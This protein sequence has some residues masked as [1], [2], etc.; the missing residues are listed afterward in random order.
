VLLPKAAIRCLPVTDSHPCP[1][2]RAL[3]GTDHCSVAALVAARCQA[4]PDAPF[5]LWGDTLLTYGQAFARM[6]GVANRLAAA[7]L[8]GPDSRVAILMPKGPD[9]ILV[10]IGAQM[11]GCVTTIIRPDLTGALLDDLL[12][13]LKP[14]CIVT[15]GAAIVDRSNVLTTVDGMLPAVLP[16]GHATLSLSPGT[17][18]GLRAV[19]PTAEAALMFTSGTTGRSKL[20]RVG[21]AYFCRGAAFLAQALAI[22]PTDVLL[23]WAPQS[24]VGNQVDEVLCCIVGGAAL[25]MVPGFSRSGFLDQLQQHKVTLFGGFSNVFK[26]LLTLP[27]GPADHTHSLRL[28]VAINTPRPLRDTF[29][30][31]F[32]VPLVDY[33][34]MTECSIATLP[35]VNQPPGS[36][37]RASP[38]VQIAILDAAGWHLPHGHTGRIALRPQV[39]DA[40]MRGYADD[41]AATVL[42]T[43]G[44]WFQT[45]DLGQ[46]DDDGNLFFADRLNDSIRSGGEN[47]A[48]SE[49]ESAIMSLAG[50]ADCVAVGIPNDLG[51]EALCV[52]VVPA[53]GTVLDPAG[54]AADCAKLLPR[55]M[56]PSRIRIV[57][58][59][60]Y[61]AVGKVDR[62][63]CRVALPTDYVVQRM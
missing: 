41:D 63:A 9:T 15:D 1:P 48:P 11:A 4:T 23:D 51:D 62:P 57:S 38:D 2:L 49:I 3:T 33:Y 21:H 36:C 16:G 47:I 40:L 25:A 58:S 39:P 32:G 43:R 54:L 37:G 44:L 14:A 6:T 18:A 61:S 19:D 7:G 55:H 30:A 13:R 60:P 20:A 52:V 35:D 56:R 29:S 27:P 17:A 10:W 26:Y 45:Q 59:L 8:S 42:A 24:H 28:A 31:R 34:G 50:I 53:E 22:G 12:N 5:I 46:M